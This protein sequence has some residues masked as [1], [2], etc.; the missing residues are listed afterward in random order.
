MFIGGPGA[1]NKSS[2]HGCWSY[3][4]QGDEEFRYP[5]STLTIKKALEKLIGK[6]NVISNSVS[7]YDSIVN[8]SLMGAE[9]ADVIVLCIGENA[10]AETPGSIKDLTLDKNQLE[11]VEKAKK[12]NKPLVV[13][14]SEGR[15][16]IINSIEPLMDAVLLA[17]WPGE[18]GAEAIV[19]TL[20]GINN[21]SGKLPYTYP[22]STGH[23]VLYD[24]KFSEM[25]IEQTQDGF[26]YQGYNPQWEFGHGLSY[27]TFEYSN[28][29][30]SSDTLKNKDS[31][32]V[33][34]TVKNTGSRSGKI[35]VE[36]YSKDHF[37]S[38]TPS[39]KRLR[40]F[41]KIN[42][43]AGQSTTILFKITAR[44]LAFVNNNL[45]TVTEQGAFT[46][47]IGNLEKEFYYQP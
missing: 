18:K 25:G 2:L 20:F 16:R 44:D 4:W 35:A 42:L 5:D 23:I 41:K 15:P 43:N 10:Y 24:C 8:Y 45:K 39:Y 3:S 32:M 12:I 30:I 26:T 22:K 13:V 21:P 47:M 7:K 28:L 34:I 38:I 19:Q 31:L 29:N 33:N 36:M 11:L 46:V 14:L 27:T 9:N 40:A 37:A 1:N 6:E 17:Y